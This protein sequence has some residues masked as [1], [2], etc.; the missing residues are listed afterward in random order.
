MV[1][2]LGNRE[3]CTYSLDT[4]GAGVGGTVHLTHDFPLRGLWLGLRQV[5]PVG[6]NMAG[7]VMGSWFVPGATR[8]EEGYLQ[9]D[10]TPM[11]RSWRTNV[12]WWTVE[13]A[14]LYNF[15]SSFAFIGGFRYDSFQTNFKDAEDIET[16]AGVPDDEADVTLSHYIPY[17][18][19]LVANRNVS[20]G[21]VGFPT[22]LG[23][24]DYKQALT[25]GI[26]R[27]IEGSGSYNGGYFL[28]LFA[29]AGADVMGAEVGVFGAYTYVHGLGNVDVDESFT[30]FATQNDSFDF[31][32]NRQAWILGG[33]IT[34]P[35]KLP[36]M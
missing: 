31:S 29:T 35:F 9:G 12:Q 1:G 14:G 16:V 4:E 34:V 7:M 13:A 19:F 32:L 20:A 17:F 36:M 30:G 11:H 21:I 26:N 6:E 2:Y 5:F 8:S 23:S 24:I 3:G 25:A 15:A 22:L 18:G 27:R 10:G 33:S 28:E